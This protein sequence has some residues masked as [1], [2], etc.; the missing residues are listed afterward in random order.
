[1]IAAIGTILAAIAT[2][3]YTFYTYKLLS[4]TKRSIDIANENKEKANKLAE[5]QIYSKLSDVLSTPKALELFDIIERNLFDIEE[6]DESKSETDSSSKREKI[7]GR[8]L[9]RFILGPIEDLAKFNED[10]IISIESIDA[11]FGNTILLLGNNEKIINY[12]Q[13]LRTK[14][15]LTDN[16]HSGFESLYEEEMERCS[17]EEKK[18]YKNYFKRNY[19]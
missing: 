13:Y 18:K 5:F 15:Y 14:V 10:Q 19:E 12:I 16:L 9:R 4:E 1:M 3:L 2:V 8:D 6:I 17:E 7:S 11:G